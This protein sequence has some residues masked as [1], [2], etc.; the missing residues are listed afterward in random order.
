[1]DFNVFVF[2][3]ILIAIFMLFG[4]SIITYWVTTNALQEQDE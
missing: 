1:M 2:L 3:G 4:V